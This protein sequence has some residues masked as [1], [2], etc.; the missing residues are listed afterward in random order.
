MSTTALRKRRGI[1]LA[2]APPDVIARFF[3]PS[4]SPSV[5][6]PPSVPSVVTEEIA[7]DSIFCD[8]SIQQRAGGL[9]R[10]LVNEYA[11]SLNEWLPSAPLIVF[12]DLLNCWLADGFHRIEAAKDCGLQTV[13]CVVRSGG[14]R[15]ALLFACGANAAHGARRTAADRR[16]AVETL[17]RDPEWSRW[18]DRRLAGAAGVTHPTVANIRA[19]LARQITKTQRAA[20]EQL[21]KFTSSP[22]PADVAHLPNAGL[23]LCRVGKDGK[24]RKP[25]APPVAPVVGSG[26]DLGPD[27]DPVEL[28]PAVESWFLPAHREALDVLSG[29][30]VRLNLVCSSGDVCSRVEALQILVD[31]IDRARDLA[32]MVRSG[33]GRSAPFYVV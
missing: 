14:Q 24:A 17:L 11:L 31:V 25:K 7:V 18:S 1:T 29:R 26:L 8:S 12:R 33:S 32:D 6:V 10:S 13:P 27:P 23:D 16:R 3:E 28:P 15:D 4:A 9:S 21:E 5:V 30:L 22:L 20:G 2:D 19:Q